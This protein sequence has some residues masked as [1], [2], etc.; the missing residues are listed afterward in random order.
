MRFG[1]WTVVETVGRK[2]RCVCDCGNQSTVFWADLKA[3]RS[4]KCR[5]CGIAAGVKAMHSAIRRHGLSNTPSHTVWVDMRRRCNQPHRPDYHR[6]GGR[7]IRVCD[8]WNESFDAFLADM[9][10]KPGPEYTLDRVDPDGPYSPE[11]CRWATRR[12]QARNTRTN[13]YVEID[14]ERMALV[15][16]AER[17]GIHYPT[18]L[19]RYLNLGWDLIDA[20]TRPVRKMACRP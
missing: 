1:K 7:G 10:Q 5:K 6:Y 4:T 3:G 19:N 17:Y 15:E 14:G 2:R 11:N 20:L 12:T 9:G 8:R 13:H 18:F 16:A